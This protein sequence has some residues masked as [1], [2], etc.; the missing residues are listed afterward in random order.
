MMIRDDNRVT[1]FPHG[2]NAFKLCENE[3]L[4]ICKAKETLKILNK[5]C[6]NEMYVT[7]NTFLKYME[8]KWVSVMKKYGKFKG[9]KKI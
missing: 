1:T 8:T 9:K 5:E 6:K 2:T 7:C 4:N 3:M